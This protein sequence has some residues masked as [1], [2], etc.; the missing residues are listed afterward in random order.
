MLAVSKKSYTISSCSGSPNVAADSWV[1]STDVISCS[2]GAF[3]QAACLDLSDLTVCPQGC[4]QIFEQLTS[5]SGDP[6]SYTP[7]LQTRYGTGCN[8]AQYVTNLHD[9]W[10]QPRMSEMLAV[11]TDLDSIQ[12]VVGD[13]DLSV[14]AVQA[15]LNTFK[16]NL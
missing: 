13:Y 4:Y 5:P 16:S 8:Y 11:Q 6:S 15:S 10:N 12:S 1:P 3:E 9:N 7:H 2:G 14:K